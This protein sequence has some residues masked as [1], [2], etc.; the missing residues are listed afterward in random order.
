MIP[1]K[2]APTNSPTRPI[3]L[4]GIVMYFHKFVET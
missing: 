4:N 1:A 2:A 3:R